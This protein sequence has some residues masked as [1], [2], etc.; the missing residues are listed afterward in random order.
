MAK[1]EAEI[2]RE[3]CDY[4]H[5]KGYFFWRSNNVPV[6]A[7]SNDGQKRFRSLPKYTP[8][9]LP[10]ITIIHKTIAIFI[11]VKRDEKTKQSKDQKDIEA[12]IRENG[13][14]YFVAWNVEIVHRLMTQIKYE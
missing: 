2:Q 7:R 10:D 9:G 4:L 12:K 14:I 11:E 13:D 5:D 1:K 3:I 8:K 6:Y